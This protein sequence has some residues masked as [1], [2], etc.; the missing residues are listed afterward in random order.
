MDLSSVPITQL[1]G[2]GPKLAEKLARIRIKTIQDAMF[3]LPLRYQ[4]RTREVPIGDLLPGMEVVC[5]G[6]IVST[7][8][9]FRRRRSMVCT[10][11]DGT[12]ALC[13]RFF[14]FNKQQRE[15]LTHGTRVRCFGE[16]RR[17]PSVLEIAVSYT[18]LTLPTKA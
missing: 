5:T 4:D 1:S 7:E 6:S 14:H 8:V 13:L 11:E 18:H 2:V 17:G 3:H 10:I 9:L 12:G 16:V 15:K